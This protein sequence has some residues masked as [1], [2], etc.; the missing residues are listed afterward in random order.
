MRSPTAEAPL[1]RVQN[2]CCTCC[3]QQCGGL[4]T[5]D[6]DEKS[7]WLRRGQD[8]RLI[9]CPPPYLLHLSPPSP[10]LSPISTGTPSP[11]GAATRRSAD[12]TDDFPFQ[13]VRLHRPPPRSLARATQASPRAAS[14]PVGLTS[15]IPPLFLCPVL[16]SVPLAPRF[17]PPFLRPISP[18]RFSAR[19]L[20]P[21]SSA[22]ANR[23]C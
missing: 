14:P 22:S 4:D 10:A 15:F 11:F 2:L 8:I 7:F 21:A 19:F 13:R 23:G 12:P 5:T 3:K 17:P 9:D 1:R 6:Y 18:T 16:R 20:C